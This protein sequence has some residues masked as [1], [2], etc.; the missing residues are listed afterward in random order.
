M[1]ENHFMICPININ[2][3]GLDVNRKKMYL[4]SIFDS[5]EIFEVLDFYINKIKLMTKETKAKLKKIFKKNYSSAVCFI[6]F[7]Q[8]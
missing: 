6:V 2:T 1:L 7:F 4:T 5:N 8:T 3:V